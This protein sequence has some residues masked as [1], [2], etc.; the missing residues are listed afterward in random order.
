MSPNLRRCRRLAILVA[1]AAIAA[2][3]AGQVEIERRKPAAKRGVLSVDS[4]F[5]SIA[6]RAWDR[7]E[8]LL[9]GQLAAGAEDVDLEVD[10]EGASVSVGVPEAWLHTT[11]E[12]PAFRSTLEIQAPAGWSVDVETL[13]AT[14]HVE[15][16]TGAVEATTVNSPVTVVGTTARV[17]V[18]TMTGSV[19][20]EARGAPLALRTISGAVVARG[21]GDEISVETVSG[22]IELAGTAVRRLEAETFTGKIEIRAELAPDG[23]IEVET[24]SSPARVVLPGSVRT[25]FDLESFSGGI[26]SAFCAGTPLVQEPYEPFRRL[27]CSTGSDESEVQIKTHSGGIVIAAD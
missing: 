7:P 4:D 20:I 18:E 24:I 21:A 5:G 17:E 15:G 26:E 23:S 1:L 14:V 3:S 27:R 25:R 8:I 6:V 22:D 10:D 11:G 19:T 9:R 2:P 12:D 13:N 16:F